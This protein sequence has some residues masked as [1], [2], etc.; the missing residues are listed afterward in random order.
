MPAADADLDVDPALA[1]AV[2]VA[3]EVLGDAARRGVSFA[4]MTTYRVGGAAALFVRLRSLDDLAL[5]AR[6]AAS[7]RLPV[8]VVGRGSNLLVADRGFAGIAVSLG[9]AADR[10]DVDVDTAVVTAGGAV[11][12]PVLA[13]RTA[14]C[15]LSGFE[16]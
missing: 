3:S 11:R 16:W 7:S 9:D 6:A 13:R 1:T 10:I 14:A 2:A 12:L 8:L 5:V 4:T 15:G